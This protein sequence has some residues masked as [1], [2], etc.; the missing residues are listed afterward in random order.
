MAAISLYE[1]LLQ[2][3]ALL[4]LSTEQQSIRSHHHLMFLAPAASQDVSVRETWTTAQFCVNM[5]TEDA[6]NIYAP[7]WKEPRCSELHAG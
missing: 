5:D 2:P 4:L 7:F 3:R 1:G 6:I